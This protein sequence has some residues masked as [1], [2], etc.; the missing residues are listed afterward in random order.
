MNLAWLSVLTVL[1]LK[2]NKPRVSIWQ[3]KGS[4][5]IVS[6]LL[7]TSEL[8]NLILSMNPKVIA[9]VKS[10]ISSALS[11]WSSWNVCKSLHSLWNTFGKS[12]FLNSSLFLKVRMFNSVCCFWG[13]NT[14]KNDLYGCDTYPSYGSMIPLNPSDLQLLDLNSWLV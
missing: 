9:S 2:P 11:S 1:N 10:L 5:R 14:G 7:Q 13:I 8:S 6:P 4:E 3:S 12:L